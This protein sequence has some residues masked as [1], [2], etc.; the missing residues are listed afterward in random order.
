LVVRGYVSVSTPSKI[1]VYGCK[2]PRPGD[3]TT[4]TAVITQAV[5]WTFELND[6]HLVG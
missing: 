4:C 5:I 2:S 3:S 6:V 1:K